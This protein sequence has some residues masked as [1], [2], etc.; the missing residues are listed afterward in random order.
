MSNYAL[1]FTHENGGLSCTP[2]LTLEQA[3]SLA[4]YWSGDAVRHPS[5]V[6]IKIVNED[7]MQAIEERKLV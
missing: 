5:W 3:E 1:F 4:E 7:T 6:N 2:D